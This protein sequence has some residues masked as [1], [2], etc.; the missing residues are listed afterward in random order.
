MA[1][2]YI[3]NLLL[4]SV[5]YRMIKKSCVISHPIKSVF[6][7]QIQNPFGFS[8]YS[9]GGRKMLKFQIDNMKTDDITSKLKHD[10]YFVTLPFL[11]L[12][13]PLFWGR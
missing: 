6:F 8:K 13:Y 4:K 7:V 10:V 9:L 2:S 12:L 5:I 3:G 11:A 1:T